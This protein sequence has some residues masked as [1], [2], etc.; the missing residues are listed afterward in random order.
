MDIEHLPDRCDVLV[1]GAGPAGSSAAAWT[2]Q[3]G[4]D[5]VIVDMAAFPRDKTCG[6]GLT[7]R[8]IHELDRLGLGEWVRT[9]V[10]N[11]GLRAAGFGQELLL[12]WPGGSLPDWGSAVPRSELDHRIL[13]RAV[14][15]GTAHIDG[16]RALDVEYGDG[17]AVRAV[18][19][20]IGKHRR[21][22]ECRHLIIADGVRSPLGRKLGRQW[23]RDT[24][25]GVAGRCYVKSHRSDDPWISSHLE[26]RGDQD[27]LLSGYGWIF[28]LG[29]G[30]VNLGVGTLATA[31]RPANIQLRPLM[32]RY[33]DL[34]RNEWGLD[35]EL[36]L[37]TS[38]M[39]PMGG[40]VSDIA[41][42]NWIMIGDA[43]ACVNPLNGEGIDYGLETGR[44]GAELI[45][46]SGRQ[47]GLDHAW[48]E[49]LRRR[50]GEAFSVARRLAGL[51][52][53]PH[54]LPA[55]GPV[56]MRSHAL[57]TV[58]LRV[59]GN[60]MTDADRDATA[61]LWRWAGRRSV[62]LDSRPPFT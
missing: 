9:H 6:D 62:R 35:D 57:M 39:L 25:Y 54:L 41:G 55:A 53:V 38:A 16:A 27:Q 32:H 11:R 20:R 26:L 33:A 50:Y 51:I 29:A 40:A 23:H 14:H 5:T 48:P 59:M 28:P 3:L 2:S 18:T 24:T 58:A 10:V 30:E 36:R 15:A 45:A 47:A 61:R 37:P 8:A 4:L 52:T 44:I 31:K 49:L 34:R 21:N 46:E 19:V 60:L 12:P 1:V 56:G 43:A 13:Q 7:P 22:I 17:G 42:P